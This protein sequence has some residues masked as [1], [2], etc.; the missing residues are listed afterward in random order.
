MDGHTSPARFL[1]YLLTEHDISVTQLCDRC[2][3]HSD[4]A[5][6]FLAG[7]LPVTQTLAEQLGI[8]FHSPGFWLTRQALWMR[9][10]SGADVSAGGDG[11]RPC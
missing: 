4:I 3:L 8:V 6:A 10:E 2:G 5:R 9:A 7:R 11:T 1:A